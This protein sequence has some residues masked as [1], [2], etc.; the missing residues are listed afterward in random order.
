MR[1]GWLREAAASQPWEPRVL[2]KAVCGQSSRKQEAHMLR[3]N[4]VTPDLVG[5]LEDQD[6][7]YAW[8]NM[9]IWYGEYCR[10]SQRAYRVLQPKSF[11]NFYWDLGPMKES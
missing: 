11:V 8:M 3:Q 10:K 4:V 5:S 2:L 9:I 6:E 7:K 1:K